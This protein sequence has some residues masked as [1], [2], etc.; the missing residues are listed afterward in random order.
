MLAQI[1]SRKRVLAIG[2]AVLVVFL[3]GTQLFNGSSN[4]ESQ[5]L[6]TVAHSMDSAPMPTYQASRQDAANSDLLLSQESESTGSTAL[7]G[8][9]A[10]TDKFAEPEQPNAAPSQATERLVIKNANVEALIDYKQMRLASTQIENMVLRLGGFIVS[11]DDASSNDEAQAYISLAFRVPADQFEKALNAFE[12]NK[13]EVVRREVS[14]QD[15]TEEFVDNQSRLANLEATAA[16]IR[17][18]LAK[19]ETIADTIKINET[20]AQYES[21][22]EVIK[23]RQ[24]FLSDSASMSLVTLMIRPKATEYSI[25]TTL[26]IGQNV[27]NALARAEKPAWTPL[28]AATG[29]WD[30][31]LAIGKDLAETLVVWAVWIPI[32]LPLLLVAWFGWRKWRKYSQSQNTSIN[33]PNPTVNQ[34]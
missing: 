6:G 27:R 15:V 8:A 5:K 18:L 34:P 13:L 7:G 1:R 25:L 20:L 22:I 30:D 10:P 9:A 16:R 32:W 31:V 26:D 3:I 24:K 28:A 2:A 12:E 33:T 19:A 21:Q 14:G 23:G 29:A 4:S 17:E 11:T